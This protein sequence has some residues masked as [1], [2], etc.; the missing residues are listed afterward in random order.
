M[1][2]KGIN[3]IIVETKENIINSINTGLSQGLPVAVIDLIVDNAVAQIKTTLNE[4]LKNE[5]ETYENAKQLENE[6]VEYNPKE[7]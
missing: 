2:L 1:A 6:Q 7:E 4:Q 5:T 3:T